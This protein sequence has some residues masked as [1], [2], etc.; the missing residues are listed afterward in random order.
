MLALSIMMPR[1]S[2]ST[3]LM[4]E[5]LLQRLRRG[6]ALA[7]TWPLGNTQGRQILEMN[8]EVN[9]TRFTSASVEDLA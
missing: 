4:V 5:S 3:D 6:T 7:S 9:G 2:W 1:S 8:L